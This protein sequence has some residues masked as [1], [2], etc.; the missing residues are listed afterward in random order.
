MPTVRFVT[1][2][3]RGVDGVA[4]AH[5]VNAD[6]RRNGANGT[7]ATDGKSATNINVTLDPSGSAC[8][9][10]GTHAGTLGYGDGNVLY[11]E[12]AGGDGGHGGRGGDGARGYTGYSG[13]DATPSSHATSGGPGGPGG[14]GGDGGRGGHAGHGA[15][16]RTQIKEDDMDLCMYLEQIPNVSGGK[17]GIG[18]NG[19]AR[20]PGGHGGSGGSGCSWTTTSSYTDSYGNTQYTTHYHSRPGA[21][22]GPDGNPGEPGTKGGD[23]DD[24]TNGSFKHVIHWKGNGTTEY[25]WRYKAKVHS[26]AFADVTTKDGIFEPGEDCTLRYSVR[27]YGPMPTPKVQDIFTSVFTTQWIYGMTTTKLAQKFVSSGNTTDMDKD[28]EFKLK[29]TD[30]PPPNVRFVAHTT[31]DWDVLVDRVRKHFPKS[32]LGEGNVLTL[33]FPAKISRFHGAAVISRSEESPLIGALHNLCRR[34]L[35][36]DA[37]RVLR[38]R[39]TIV[40]DE[41]SMTPLNEP[42]NATLVDVRGNAI[43]HWDIPVNS[44]ASKTNLIP[45]ALLRFGNESKQYSKVTLGAELFLGK[46]DSFMVERRIQRMSIAVQLAAYYKPGDGKKDFLIVTSHSTSRES[47]LRWQSFAQDRGLTTN[48][49]NATMHDGINLSQ[50]VNGGR[51]M[52][53]CAHRTVIIENTSTAFLTVTSN[54]RTDEMKYSADTLSQSE[55]AKALRDQGMGFLIIGKVPKLRAKLMPTD[56]AQT[57]IPVR[58]DVLATRTTTWWVQRFRERINFASL[59]MQFDEV[60]LAERHKKLSLAFGDKTWFMLWGQHVMRYGEN[61]DKIIRTV[62][63]DRTKRISSYLAQVCPEVSEKT[64]RDLATDTT[65]STDAVMAALKRAA[66]NVAE[67]CPS[68][69]YRL[70]YSWVQ[71]ASMTQVKARKILAESA[72]KFHDEIQELRP[73]WKFVVAFDSAPHILRGPQD[74]Q[75]FLPHGMELQIADDAGKQCTFKIERDPKPPMLQ[76]MLIGMMKIHRSGDRNGPGQLVAFEPQGYDAPSAPLKA[77]T[78]DHL[79]FPVVKAM[80]FDRKLEVVQDETYHERPFATDNVIAAL[81]SDLTEEQQGLRRMQWSDRVG[82]KNILDHCGRLCAFAACVAEIAARGKEG[83]AGKTRAA[84]S[85]V[86][87]TM[88]VVIHRWQR[89]HDH[90]MFMRRWRVLTSTCQPVLEK[91]LRL[92]TAVDCINTPVEMTIRVMEKVKKFS[93]EELV[94]VCIL[95][96]PGSTLHPTGNL[97]LLM[98]AAPTAHL[99]AHQE[100]SKPSEVVVNRWQVKEPGDRGL[101]VHKLR[102]EVNSEGEIDAKCGTPGTVKCPLK[103]N[104]ANYAAPATGAASCKMCE[105]APASGAVMLGCKGCAWSICKSCFE[106]GR[107]APWSAHNPTGNKS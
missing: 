87:A 106:R 37:G 1:T 81:V 20:G 8:A 58:E 4:G 78:I 2:G 7:H 82:D 14:H 91:A 93:L 39:F 104:L 34:A 102:Q 97:E 35:G 42:N 92:I 72:R 83:S 88:S 48:F 68:N 9:L 79:G 63:K 61:P 99:K 55:T 38:V 74:K 31:A 18:G 95:G 32:E 54:A 25:D 64:M 73:G 12:A 89:W 76:Y 62:E 52:D 28:I 33:Q 80:P 5:G 26:Q 65:V 69:V 30:E 57:A 46:V 85:Q 67:W 70:V 56:L 86:C 51:L 43:P 71:P 6:H 47:F 66:G 105:S 90:V 53:D 75:K 60:H 16:I 59:G 24:G 11:L 22:D 96:R 29:N 94:Q 27:N 100:H 107:S 98:Q 15:H 23:G 36:H 40:K 3:A 50:E 17:K 21:S 44:L 41:N 77:D 101:M 103:H 84:L 45:G 19:G 49:W 13:S 10:T